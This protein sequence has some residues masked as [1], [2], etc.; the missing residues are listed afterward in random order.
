MKIFGMLL[1]ITAGTALG[2]CAGNDLRKRYRILLELKNWIKEVKAAL[3][4]FS[5]EHQKP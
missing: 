2:N 5:E 3:V 1:I 4:F